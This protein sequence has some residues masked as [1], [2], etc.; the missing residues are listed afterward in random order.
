MPDGEAELARI[1]RLV[2]SMCCRDRASVQLAA[3]RL[4]AY[5]VH[6]TAEAIEQDLQLASCEHCAS[7]T[8]AQAPQAEPESVRPAV[9]RATASGWLTSML[10]GSGG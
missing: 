7:R 8:A 3:Q 10:D 2:H 6:R 1:R 4:E 9:H 5:G